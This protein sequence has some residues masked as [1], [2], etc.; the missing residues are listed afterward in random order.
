MPVELSD[1]D[2]RL[3]DVLQ[4]ELPLTPHPYRDIAESLGATEATVLDRVHALSGPPP[5]PIRQISAI[6]DSKSLGYQSCLVAAKVEPPRIR[7]A[8]AIINRHPGVSHNYEREHAFNL[9]F[10]LAVPPDSRL[11]LGRTIDLLQELAG[12][13]QM[14]LMPSLK[15]YKIGV[16]FDLGVDGDAPAA[17]GDAVAGAG[18]PAPLT[19][20]DKRIIR[21][22][23]EHLPV[24]SRPFDDRADEASVTVDELLAAASRFRDVGVMRRFSAVLRH[25]AIGVSANAMGVWVVPPERQDEFGRIAAGFPAVSHCYLRPSYPPDWPYSLFTM[26]HGKT[27]IDCE[28]TLAA[29]SLATGVK[30]Y[31]SLY[32]TVEFKKVRVKYF[33]GEIE[34]WEA[35]HADAGVT[36]GCSA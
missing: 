23:Q 2:R 33:V 13:Q 5:A 4:R 11:G 1:F 21:V 22:L 12:A 30:D 10:T 20:S 26:V 35:K 28:A 8:A 25:R 32:S 6:F 7:Q 34:E 9:W 31:T 17:N 14:R 3:L 24:T 15:L 16:K 19:E 27:R 29:I 36:C 18:S